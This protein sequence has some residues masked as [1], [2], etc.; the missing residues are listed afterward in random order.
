MV[1]IEIKDGKL[2]VTYPSGEVDIYE[3]SHYE[4]C[5]E[6]CQTRIA[7][8]QSRVLNATNVIVVMDE[9]M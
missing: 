5:I 2:F 1:E 4:I 8:L 7:E 6:H 9:N 3:R